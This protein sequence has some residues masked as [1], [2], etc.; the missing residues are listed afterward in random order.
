MEVHGKRLISLDRL[1]ACNELPGYHQVLVID[2]LDVSCMKI[3][4]KHIK[5]KKLED[6]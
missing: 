5:R 6:R 2:S 4:A 3:F 1:G